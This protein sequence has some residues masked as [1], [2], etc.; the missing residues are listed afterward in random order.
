MKEICSL[1]RQ[2][3]LRE[4]KA[5]SF[6]LIL[7]LIIGLTNILQP[8]ITG[9]F[10]D[11]LLLKLEEKMFL[12]KYF[13]IFT[14]LSGLIILLAYI[15]N[16]IS[17]KVTTKIA[18]NIN[19]DLISHLQSISISTLK[20]YDIAYLTQKINEDANQVTSYVVDLISNIHVNF[21]LLGFCLIYTLV[22]S[23]VLFLLFFVIILIYVL[24]YCAMRN[25]LYDT[26]YEFKEKQS[27]FFGHLTEQLK[28]N[29]LIKG[30]SLNNF[31]MK[32][33]DR[34]F[35]ELLSKLM[36]FQKRSYLFN[37][38]DNMMAILSQISVFVVGGLLIFNGKIT[39]GDFTILASY[40]NI[41][42]SSFKY[43]FELGGKTQ[44]VRISS[45]RIQEIYNLPMD[46]NGDIVVDQINEIS[47]KNV[48]LYYDDV[49]IANN[50]TAKLNKGKIYGIVGKNGKG[51]SSLISAIVGMNESFRGSIEI[52]GKNV[53]SINMKKARKEIISICEQEVQLF[54]DTIESNIKLDNNFENAELDR[55]INRFNLRDICEINGNIDQLSG[56]EK[57]KIACIRTLLKRC[58]LLIFDEPTANLDEES[59]NCLFKYLESKKEQQIIVIVSHDIDIMKHIDEVIEL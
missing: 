59:K 34:S 58:D 1:I 7:S 38:L 6:I 28:L 48:E 47:I 18:Y 15:N 55:V 40:M 29:I 22:M 5:I 45:N 32:R 8:Y 39:V 19:R 26:G 25:R 46:S 41:L 10:I 43:F 42:Q 36:P 31:V 13:A 4:K 50:I 14:I 53:K 52:N 27:V 57:R 37:S 16:I 9:S 20:K 23:K 51:K 56:G 2:Y 21:I 44:S 33:L 3:I 24:L 54:Q 30:M 11:T 35:A 12:I 17:V 49:P